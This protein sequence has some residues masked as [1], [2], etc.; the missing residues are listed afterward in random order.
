[1][2]TKQT[3]QNVIEFHVYNVLLPKDNNVM[4][5]VSTLALLEP[6]SDGGMFL[7]FS[8]H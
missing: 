1:M 2:N 8:E 4:A 5:G 7:V 3:L 6:S